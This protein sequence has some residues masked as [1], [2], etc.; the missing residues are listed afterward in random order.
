[1][2]HY[3]RNVML[4]KHYLTQVLKK[5]DIKYQTFGMDEMDYNMWIDPTIWLKL[6]CWT[7]M[8]EIHHMDEN[9]PSNWQ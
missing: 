8:H 4:L 6:N 1:M 5:I 2:D 9:G 7:S 3:F